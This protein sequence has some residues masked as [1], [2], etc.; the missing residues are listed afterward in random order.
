[1]FPVQSVYLT[2]AERLFHDSGP[3]VVERLVAVDISE[4][5][6]CFLNCKK[7]QHYCLLSA[8]VHSCLLTK[9]FQCT[10]G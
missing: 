8:S 5:P 4:L 6:V 2:V 9:G 10:C 3:F 1:M 7:M